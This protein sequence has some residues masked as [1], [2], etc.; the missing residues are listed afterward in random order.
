M[1]RYFTVVKD[2]NSGTYKGAEFIRGNVYNADRI[3]VNKVLLVV[4]EYKA[5][6]KINVGAWVEYFIELNPDHI[7]KADDIKLIAAA[8][9][10]LEALK[11]ALPYLIKAE[12]DGM[13]TAV[14]VKNVV[15]YVDKVIKKATE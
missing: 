1:S 8:P 7:K 9:E 2:L 3:G 10:L 5:L 4:N 11:T 13:N 15:K 6:H 14:P 12:I